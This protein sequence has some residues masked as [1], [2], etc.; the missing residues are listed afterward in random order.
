MARLLVLSCLAVRLCAAESAFGAVTNDECPPGTAV[1]WV[2]QSFPAASIDGWS[3][4]CA[5]G[6]DS[7][8]SGGSGKAVTLT[9]GSGGYSS[10]AHSPTR[11][12]S[13]MD[14]AVTWSTASNAQLGISFGSI[15]GQVTASSKFTQIGV[16]SILDGHTIS[17]V[18]NLRSG[19]VFKVDNDAQ[20]SGRATKASGPGYVDPNGLDLLSTTAVNWTLSLRPESLHIGFNGFNDALVL[21]K[22]ASAPWV[23]PA[24]ELV[25]LVASVRS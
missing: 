22:A 3:T 9:G 1:A 12:R 23:D 21:K 24:E 10:Y 15:T 8:L 6:V 14:L 17:P 5:P 13:S 25:R 18:V 2:S 4:V 20:V 19:S 7:C 16:G 11:W